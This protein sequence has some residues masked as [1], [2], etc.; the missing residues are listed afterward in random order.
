MKRILIHENKNLLIEICKD[1]NQ[2][3]PHLEQVKKT[4]E[5]LQL[6]NFNDDILKQI[7]RSGTGQ[8]E[9]L[10]NES[11]NDQVEKAGI[12]NTIL[13]SNILKDSEQL[14]F[15]FL[16]KTREL[17]RFTPETF[18]RKNYL[19]LNVI[20]FQN[21]IFYLSDENKEQIIE[22]ECRIYIEN[23]KEKELF[24]NLQNFIEA[25][26]KVSDNLK[27][28]EF[29]FRYEQGKG[30]TAIA[31]GFLWLELDNTYSIRLETLK[32]ATNYKEMSL[33]FN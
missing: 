8:I 12:S 33:K 18:S 19:K 2:Y 17:K 4:Y 15:S 25:Y 24:D 27:E 1:L 23:E 21:G 22:N 14:Y 11:L 30:V 13:K 7:V 31:N 10:F 20:S 9:K 28:L 29:K 3:L 26:N 32:F 6:G 5:K 16:E